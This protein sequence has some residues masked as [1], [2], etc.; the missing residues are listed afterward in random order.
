[1]YTLTV[2]SLDAAAKYSHLLTVGGTRLVK[3]T[4]EGEEVVY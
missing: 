4:Y 1:M 3:T 2:K